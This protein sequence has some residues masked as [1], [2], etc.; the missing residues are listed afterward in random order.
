MNKLFDDTLFSDIITINKREYNAADVAL[1][2]IMMDEL[3][4][5]TNSDFIHAMDMELRVMLSCMSTQDVKIIQY[6][7][8]KVIQEYDKQQLRSRVMKKRRL[9]QDLNDKQEFEKSINIIKNLSIERFPNE[10]INIQPII[11]EIGGM[12]VI[13]DEPDETLF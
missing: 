13:T 9:S 10:P 4:G 3:V 2:V 7:K 11:E 12:E 8:L 6:H 1:Y 5:H